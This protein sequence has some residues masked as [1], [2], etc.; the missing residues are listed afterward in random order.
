MSICL[1][2]ISIPCL[3]SEYSIVVKQCFQNFMDIGT[4]LIMKNTNGTPYQN[5]MQLKAKQTYTFYF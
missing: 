3:Q 2:E 1:L 4:L 5:K